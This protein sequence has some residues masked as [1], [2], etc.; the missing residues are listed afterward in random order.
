VRGYEHYS[1]ADFE[2]DGTGNRLKE[3]VHARNT[4]S[5]SAP[6]VEPAACYAS[7]GEKKAQ[8]HDGLCHLSVC[9]RRHRLADPGGCSSKYVVDAIVSTGVL[10]DDSA[11]FI[12]EPVLEWQEKIPTTQPEETILTLVWEDVR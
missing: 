6:N 4:V 9:S 10:E 3:N 1:E 2:P 7:D 5:A 11:K 12:A 8:R